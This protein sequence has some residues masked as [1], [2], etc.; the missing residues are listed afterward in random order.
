MSTSL[1]QEWCAARLSALRLLNQRVIAQ[2]EA[3]MSEDGAVQAGVLLEAAIIYEVCC[4]HQRTLACLMRELSVSADLGFTGDT[5]C[6]KSASD[7]TSAQADQSPISSLSALCD[8]RATI[9]SAQFSYDELSS[10]FDALGLSHQKDDLHWMRDEC[11][12]HNRRLET[13]VISHQA[14]LVAPRTPLQQ[15]PG[16]PTNPLIH[17]CVAGHIA[18]FHAATDKTIQEAC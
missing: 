13:L 4:R 1:Y 15:R 11:A 7:L 12:A 18:S 16:E 3:L 14:Q 8:L 17:P 2:A 10:A 9:A 5:T 6:Q